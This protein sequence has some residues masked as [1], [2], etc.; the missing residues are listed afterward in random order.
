MFEKKHILILGLITLG[1]LV[2]LNTNKKLT[3]VEVQEPVQSDKKSFD[4]NTLPL[5]L[6]P[7]KRLGDN[8]PV[9]NN[10]VKKNFSSIFNFK[11]R[12]DNRPSFFL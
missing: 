1:V 2:Y 11:P 10:V 6:M 12:L 4:S 3:F 5:N 7:P 8:E 9:P